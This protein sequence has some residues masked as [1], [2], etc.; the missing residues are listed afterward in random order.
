MAVDTTWLLSG[1]VE[2]DAAAGAPPESKMAALTSFAVADASGVNALFLRRLWALT[3]LG[4]G[5][6]PRGFG[7]I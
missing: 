5:V 1:P 6:R 3:R 4:F 7:L 2:G